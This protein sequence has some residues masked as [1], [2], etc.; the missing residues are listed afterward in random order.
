AD[1]QLE[2]SQATNPDRISQLNVDKIFNRGQ[3]IGK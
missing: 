2:I 3:F 1:H